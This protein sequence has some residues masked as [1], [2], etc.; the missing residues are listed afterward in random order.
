MEDP[1]SVAAAELP[2]AWP[3]RWRAMVVLRRRQAAAGFATL[4]SERRAR[5]KATSALR[6]PMSGMEV[7]RIPPITALRVRTKAARANLA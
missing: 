5:T 1:R 4:A 7:A 6:G 3:N 2:G